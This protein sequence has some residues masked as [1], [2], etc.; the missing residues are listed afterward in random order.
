MWP[1][2]VFYLENTICHLSK[3][4]NYVKFY[5]KLCNCTSFEGIFQNFCWKLVNYDATW[6]RR[7]RLY[8]TILNPCI[9]ISFITLIV[10]IFPEFFAH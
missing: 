3:L 5:L 10:N 4:I 6:Q 1:N 2:F 8:G 9:M 7:N